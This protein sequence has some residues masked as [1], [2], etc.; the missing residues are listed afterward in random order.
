[1]STN[2][3]HKVTPKKKFQK[4]DHFSDSPPIRA[5]R[6]RDIVL[7]VGVFCIAAV[8]AFTGL[9]NHPFWDDEANTAII[10]KNLLQTGHFSAWDG[11]NVFGYR[12]GADLD[13]NLNNIGD[14]PLQHVVAAAG[15]WLFGETTF[16]GRIIFMFA[17]LLALI[18]LFFWTHWHLRGQVA[19]WLPTLLV[20]LSPAYL[21]YI[22]QCRYY[23]IAMLLSVLILT[24]FSYPKTVNRPTFCAILASGLS[25][26]LL[27]LTNYLCAV[28]LAAVLP[29]FM[30]L[31]R[32]RQKQQ[33]LLIGVTYVAFFIAGI[34][35]L[36]E[37]NPFA[38]TGILEGDITGLAR[39]VSLLWLHVTGLG[40][41]EFFP[42]LVPLF[43]VILLA[44][45]SFR[46]GRSLAIEGL[47]IVLVMCC[48]IVITVLFTPQ[49]IF[50][51]TIADMRY[52]A[53]LIL[54]GA[55]ATACFI[56]SLWNGAHI[57]YRTIA[58]AILVLVVTT[59]IFCLNFINK[60]PLSATI[61]K[62]INENLHPYTTGSES[63]IKYLRS[64]PEK[65]VVQIFPSYMTNQALFYAPKLH[66][67][68]Q[69][70]PNRTIRANVRVNL[71][72]YVFNGRTKPDYI[73]VGDGQYSPEL[74]LAYFEHKHG[75][76]AYRIKEILSDD[77]RD[78]SRPEIP[79]HSFGPPAES[80]FGGP[81]RGFVVLERVL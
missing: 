66:Y 29:M 54:I 67:C 78:M 52:V 13:E 51:G 4:R 23:P 5:M 49:P 2:K 58:F 47:F 6:L 8:L 60:Q 48:Y 32:Y 26:C 27:M 40:S 19:A 28:A 31:K 45:K 59:N 57:L 43:L 21:M 39:L 16:G 15:I 38:A 74:V 76:G 36:I 3:K 70:M 81:D 17:G 41:F 35:I 68:C 14:P 55:V 64:L 44:I 62:Y 25:A 42:L 72:E 79:L 30:L 11:V 71:P 22:R 75:I 33:Y 80:G 10:G 1:M 69:L 20:A 9:T 37:A 65:T 34:Y 12:F 53:P 61:Y 46:N 7:L 73:F 18:P 24:A 50:R 56:Q 77:W 63:L